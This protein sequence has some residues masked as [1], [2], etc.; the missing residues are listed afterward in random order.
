MLAKSVK[1]AENS[2]LPFEC[3]FRIMEFCNEGD[4]V[5]SIVALLMAVPSLYRLINKNQCCFHSRS[6]WYPVASLGMRYCSQLIVEVWV[7]NW[8][9][10]LNAIHDYYFPY[11]HMIISPYPGIDD[12]LAHFR[13]K[14]RKRAPELYRL[15]VLIDAGWDHRCEY[16]YS[17]SPECSATKK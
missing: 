5:E 3:W 8:W 2:K 1:N 4:K 11:E 13:G 12:K 9:C 14:L 17:E 10:D 15:C 6:K 7:D 16:H